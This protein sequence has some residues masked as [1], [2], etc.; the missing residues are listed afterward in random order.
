MIDS[1]YVLNK[2]EF[3]DNIRLRYGWTIPGLPATCACG[4]K[5][6]IQHEMSCKKGGFVN[7]RHNEVRDITAHLLN[8]VCKDVSVEPT[9]LKMN[10]ERLS[11]KTSKVNDE[12]RLDVS[13]TG[14]WI[15]GQRAFFDVRVFD[16][17][18]KRYSKQSLKQCYAINETEKKRHYNE[19]I[20][21]VDQGSFTPLVFTISGGMAHEC[22]IFFSR[23]AQMIS[24]K[25]NLQQSIVV[26]WI[27]RKINFAL[28]RSM[29]MCLRGSRSIR[30]PPSITSNDIEI[31]NSIQKV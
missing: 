12:V 24:V 31:D 25:R 5:F 1:D 18:A 21:K 3:W 20:L 17:N 19:R 16:P 8:E 4:D 23:L 7:L 22:R 26:N 10:G 27:R 28:I 29:L 13:A 15:K 11:N 30:K 6:T 2:Q 9:L 14:F